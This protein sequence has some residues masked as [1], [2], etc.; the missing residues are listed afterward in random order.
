MEA[1]FEHQRLSREKFLR[2]AGLA[3]AGFI[4]AG[5]IPQ[6]AGARPSGARRAAAGPSLARKTVM[7]TTPLDVEVLR[8]FFNTQRKQAALPGNGERIIVVDANL[9]TVKQHTQVD[10]MIDQGADAIV[11]FVLTVPGWEATVARATKKGIG[12]FNHSASPIG[13]CTQNVGLDQR[14]AGFAVGQAAAGWIDKTQGGSA[15]IGLLSILNDPQ[16]TLRSTGFKAAIKQY[17]PKS[18]IAREAFAQTRDV[19]ASAAANMLQA[20]PDLSVIFSGGDDPG[21]GALT[22][23]HEAGKN[24]PKTFY[25]GSCDGTQAVIDEIAKGGIYQSTWSFLFDYSATALQ[26][27]IEKFLR[28][29]K[30]QPTRIERGRIIYYGNLK[31]FTKFANF[32]QAPANQKYYSD[33]AVMEYSDIALK[34]GQPPLDAFPKKKK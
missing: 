8:E 15:Q 11:L 4:F 27:D 26:R 10:Q 13:G 20:I 5:G 29:Q 24:D 18:V 12:V 3:G 2:A 31:S 25:I 7:I 30:V 19:G 6:V 23:A 22:A 17:S 9:D 34:T 14:A 33:P 1:P 16:L 32:P 28:G 21:L